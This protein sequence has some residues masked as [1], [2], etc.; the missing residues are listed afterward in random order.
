M[1][2][3][4]LWYSRYAV[5]VGAIV[6]LLQAI[7]GRSIGIIT[8]LAVLLLGG[9]FLVF[10]AVLGWDGLGLPLQLEMVM[11]EDGPPP[12]APAPSRPER[13]SAGPKRKVEAVPEDPP[14]NRAVEPTGETGAASGPKEPET[15]PSNAATP[16]ARSPVRL[17]TQAL[18][19]DSPLVGASCGVCSKRLREGQV[20]VRCPE[21]RAV[22]HAS[23]WTDNGFACGVE[24]CR[25][26]GSLEA[27]AGM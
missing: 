13:A 7:T 26:R 12:L 8:L 14:T 27:P 5:W 9:G 4:L 3:T 16:Q 20:V 2:E 25:G 15:A 24:D 19:A 10:I 1:L 23:C 6:L 18:T 11:M 17:R 22:Q 21:C